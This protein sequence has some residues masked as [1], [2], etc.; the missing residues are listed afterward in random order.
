MMNLPATVDDPSLLQHEPL[1]NHIA[2]YEDSGARS[3][4]R[5]VVSSFVK[6][7]QGD[8]QVGTRNVSLRLKI[9]TPLL[10]A[11]LASKAWAYLVFDLKNTPLD[12]SSFEVTDKG[13]ELYRVFFEYQLKLSQGLKQRCINK[14]CEYHTHVLKRGIGA[15]KLK[16]QSSNTQRSTQE[17]DSEASSN[18]QG[19]QHSSRPHGVS[20]PKK[21]CPQTETGDQHPHEGLVH[22]LVM[23]VTCS[24]SYIDRRHR[25]KLEP[26]VWVPFYDG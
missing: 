8:G 23:A 5:M 6:A 19:D 12:D 17:R 18:G 26:R 4:S 10:Q 14:A 2:M 24:N 13:E 7:M 16:C 20:G 9:S 1:R 25:D 21:D 15:I 3:N 22:F 11:A